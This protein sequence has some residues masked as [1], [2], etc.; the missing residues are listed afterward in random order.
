M[1]YPIIAKFSIKSIPFFKKFTHFFEYFPALVVVAVSQTPYVGADSI[2]VRS[3]KSGY[4]KAGG[5]G[6]R[7]YREEIRDIDFKKG[8]SS[9]NFYT[10]SAASV[11]IFPG[12]KRGKASKRR[13][14][15]YVNQMVL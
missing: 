7:T 13:I 6:I 12:E 9:V 4:W 14:N 8:L 2:S 15:N 3:R 1:H 11:I 10:E 5:Y